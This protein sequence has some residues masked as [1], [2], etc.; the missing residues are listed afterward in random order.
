[1]RRA[2]V[3]LVPGCAS[4]DHF[5]DLSGTPLGVYLP[6]MSMVL[7]EPLTVALVDDYDVVLI[8]LAHLFD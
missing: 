5:L 3:A 7:A 8:G 1:M 6:R 2:L 4:L